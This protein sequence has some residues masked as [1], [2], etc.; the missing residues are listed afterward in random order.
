MKKY[1]NFFCWNQAD[2]FLE[3]VGDR[4]LQVLDRGT[5]HHTNA[6]GSKEDD[7]SAL[8]SLS[9]IQLSENQTRESFAS[10]IVKS[11]GNLPEVKFL[12]LFL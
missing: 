12:V 2:P 7:D 3:L 5:E 9:L 4:K 8:K 1:A 6:Y 11:L 10:E